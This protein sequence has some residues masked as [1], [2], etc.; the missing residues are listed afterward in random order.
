MVKT[1]S[2]VEQ[3]VKEVLKKLE[4]V[5]IAAPATQS[6]DDANQEWEMIIEEIGEAKQGVNVDEV[7]IGVSPGF[8]IKFKKNII[9]I[10][11][12]NI[13]REIISGITEQGLKAR[14]VR[15]KHTA[16]VG[17]IAHT[18]A[19][20]SGSGIG[21][22]IQSRGTVVIH[23]K[24]LQ[25]L[26][27]LELF[28]QCPVLTLETYRA[29]GRNAALYAKGE[30]PTPVPV[31]NDQMARPKYQ[32]IAAVMHN[33][34]TKYVQTGAKPVELKVSFARKGGNKSDR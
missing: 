12:G 15:V 21:I 25:P 8:Y 1:E 16:D 34:E 10:P 33:F 22:G 4:N 2:L 32:A 29:I 17:F 6:S 7:V 14:I 9:G 27:N 20:L 23:Q 26:N 24:D 5:E 18:A 30:S 28:P 3:I 11:L 19:K 13:L 31:Q